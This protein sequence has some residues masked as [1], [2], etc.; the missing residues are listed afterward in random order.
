LLELKNII[1]NELPTNI[2]NLVNK[3]LYITFHNLITRKKQIKH[4]YKDVDNLLD[5]IIRSCYLP[6][7]ID[8]NQAYKNKYIDGMLPYFFSSERNSQKTIHKKSKKNKRKVMYINVLTH[9]KFNEILNVKNEHTNLH[10]VLSGINDVHLFFIKG[11]NTQM[12]SYTDRW[13]I[14]EHFIFM[15]T[16]ILEIVFFYAMCIIKNIPYTDLINRII[17]M[18]VGLFIKMLFAFNE[19]F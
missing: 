3:K 1:K 6:F 8:Y 9:D 13:S 17:Q 2:C 5:C 4:T 7:L 10:R 11:K 16:R 12:C 14:Y 18:A 19:C 15:L